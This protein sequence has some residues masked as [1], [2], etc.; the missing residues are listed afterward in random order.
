MFRLSL[1]AFVFVF[2]A[3]PALAVDLTV[4]G[5]SYPDTVTIEG[6]VLKRLGAGLRQKWIVDVYTLAAY[7]ASGNCAPA[8]IVNEDAAKYM[9]IDML[10]DVSAQKMG[11]TIS[12]SFREHMPANASDLLKK[13]SDE[14]QGYF[15]E[16]CSKKTVLE[17]YYIPGKGTTIQQNGKVLGP[18]LVGADFAKVLW[19]IYFGS[20]TCCKATKSQILESCGK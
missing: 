1:V 17:F 20:K 11:D 7:S 5:N 3:L 8:T 6:K 9:R 14:F 15:K 18:V 19:D 10:R 12:G 16:K 4:E 2:T 13:Q